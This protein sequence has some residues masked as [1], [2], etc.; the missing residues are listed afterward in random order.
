MQL[1]YLFNY[2][3]LISLPNENY[4]NIS[5]IIIRKETKKGGKNKLLYY[6]I[7]YRGMDNTFHIP[8]SYLCKGEKKLKIH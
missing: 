8:A 1:I 7:M 5:I 2:L 3:K 6:C 4:Y